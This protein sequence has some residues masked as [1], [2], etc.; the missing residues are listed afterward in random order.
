MN[1]GRQNSFICE[2]K[3][4]PAI[5]LPSLKP[6]SRSYPQHNACRERMA[7]K[8]FGHR[9]Y[10]LATGRRPR[11]PRQADRPGPAQLP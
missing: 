5:V 10:R 3:Y 2:N 7:R 4:W 1:E 11:H 8:A 6:L 9:S